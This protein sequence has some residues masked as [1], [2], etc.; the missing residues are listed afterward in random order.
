MT[1]M[2]ERIVQN[3]LSEGSGGEDGEFNLLSRDKLCY[4]IKY[5]GLGVW[6]VMAFNH[7]M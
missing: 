5:T 4:P 6:K 1:N 7:T 2:I 3:F